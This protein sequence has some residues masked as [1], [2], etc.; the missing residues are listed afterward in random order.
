M[1]YHCSRISQ[2]AYDLPVPPSLSVISTSRQLMSMSSY[3]NKQNTDATDEELYEPVISEIIY[4]VAAL[5]QSVSSFIL[6]TYWSTF[7]AHSFLSV[8]CSK[9]CCSK[10]AAAAAGTTNMRRQWLPMVE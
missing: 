10:L 1:H 5:P 8:S 7:L 9:T 4:L 6:S 3:E 2:V